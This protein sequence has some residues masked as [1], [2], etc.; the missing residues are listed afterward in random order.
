M[1]DFAIPSDHNVKLKQVEKGDKYLDIAQE[2]KKLWKIKVTNCNWCSRY[3]QR[4]G[5]GTGRLRN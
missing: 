1:V 4:I 3:R 2:L 5:T